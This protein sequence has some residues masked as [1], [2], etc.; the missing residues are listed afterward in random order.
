MVVARAMALQ[1]AAGVREA[2]ALVV[3]RATRVA[4]AWAAGRVHQ[5]EAGAK[6][7]AVGTQAG[8]AA[9]AATQEVQ[10]GDRQA[11][12]GMLAPLVQA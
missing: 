5:R 1:T 10:P 7:T 8:T 4:V 12:M 11:A 9:E 3:L 2:A 6:G